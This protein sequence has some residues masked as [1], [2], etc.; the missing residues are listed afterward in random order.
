M[1]NGQ[2]GCDGGG[3]FF[4]RGNKYDGYVVVKAPSTKI[5]PSYLDVRM[6]TW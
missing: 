1:I 3:M 6:I 5:A 4:Q 2:T